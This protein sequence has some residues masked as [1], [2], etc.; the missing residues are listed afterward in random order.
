M[1]DQSLDRLALPCP[2]IQATD[3]LQIGLHRAEKRL[4]AMPVAGEFPHSRL[5]ITWGS[6]LVLKFVHEAGVGCQIRLLLQQLANEPTQLQLARQG[7]DRRGQQPSA[8]G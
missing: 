3:D 5:R 1:V 8:E 7:R 6:N 2:G 4:G